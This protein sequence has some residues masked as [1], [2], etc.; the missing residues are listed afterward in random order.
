MTS[1]FFLSSRNGSRNRINCS[2]S[3]LWL[4]RANPRPHFFIRMLSQDLW[5][6][7][8]S[9][10]GAELSGMT[11][12]NLYPFREGG[13]ETLPLVVAVFFFS[14]RDWNWTH[15]CNTIPLLSRWPVLQQCWDGPWICLVSCSGLCIYSPLPCDF[16]FG[17]AYALLLPWGR[18]FR[19]LSH[20]LNRF[21]N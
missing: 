17:P 16:C 9:A 1:P 18:T 14:I 4:H 8:H 10:S 13:S 6:Y 7:C 19:H 12:T 2:W 15:W 21:C 3:D 5:R 11:L 20:D